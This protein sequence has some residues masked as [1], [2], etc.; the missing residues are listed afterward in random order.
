MR[1]DE[2]TSL[3]SRDD[4]ESEI[5]KVAGRTA[6]WNVE[7]L[8][9]LI[10]RYAIESAR[11]WTLDY[12]KEEKA[13]DDGWPNLGPGASDLAYEVTRCVACLKVKRWPQFYRDN[14]KATGHRNRC[15][16]CCKMHIGDDKEER[17]TRTFTCRACG[18]TKK[19]TD[20]YKNSGTANGYDYRCKS[21]KDRKS[22][23]IFKCKLCGAEKP[24]WAFPPGKLDDPRG[25][26]GCLECWPEGTKLPPKK[27]REGYRCR[28]CGKY[29]QADEFPD[30]KKESP[31]S[32]HYCL[33]CDSKYPHDKDYRRR[34]A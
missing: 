5:W 24:Q 19:A 33:A 31:A 22:P 29:K 8:L 30:G 15:M 1:G 13:E 2:V 16:K 27:E 10:D 4:L 17:P 14:T 9:R 25:R 34:S 23:K 28:D 32:I 11:K 21:C 7:R 18:G 6:P 12:P 26:W 3:I 20:F